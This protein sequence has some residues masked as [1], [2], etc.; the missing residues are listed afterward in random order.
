MEEEV[1]R[2][3]FFEAFSWHMPSAEKHENSPVRG[4]LTYSSTSGY[5]GLKAGFSKGPEVLT[6]L[7]KY[8][9]HEI[10]YHN[11]KKKKK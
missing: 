1:C 8:I 9:K 2:P 3:L 5:R 6:H 7:T 11:L 10:Y 4:S